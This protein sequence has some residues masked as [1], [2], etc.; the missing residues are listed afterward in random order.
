MEVWGLNLA[1]RFLKSPFFEKRIKGM[2]EFKV[3]QEQVFGHGKPAKRGRT[4]QEPRAL[5]VATYAKWITDNRLVEFLF[6]ENLHS[7][8]IKRSACILLVLAQDPEKL[9]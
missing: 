2:N 3:V 4:P 5:D 7:E 8:L 6:E 1:L 9:P